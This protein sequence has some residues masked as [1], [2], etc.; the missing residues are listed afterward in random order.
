[1]RLSTAPL[2]MSLIVINIVLY[3]VDF[4]TNDRLNAAFEMLPSAVQHGEWWR[5]FTYGFMHGNWPH[6]LINMYALFQA[7]AFVE[8]CYGTPRYAI[9]YLFGLIGGGVAAYFSTISSDVPTVGAS[10]A[11]LGV[12]GAM[13]ILGFKLPR[14]RS[15]LLRA[16]LLPILLTLGYGLFNPYVSNSGHIGG[17]LAGGLAATLLNPVRGR[18]LAPIDQDQSPGGDV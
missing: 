15:E 3:G 6:V 4:L 8:Y 13:V 17:L 11:I 12:F 1:V 2:T 18:E 5:F 10:G 7:G 9:I 14:L 16:A